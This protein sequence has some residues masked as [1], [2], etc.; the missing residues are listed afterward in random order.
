M[1]SRFFSARVWPRTIR[2]VVSHPTAPIAMNSPATL[3]RPK[4]V[5]KMITMNR[6]GSEYNTSTKRIISS[7]VRPPR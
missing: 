5:E 7:S 4:T 6:Y 2:A 1:N 3:L